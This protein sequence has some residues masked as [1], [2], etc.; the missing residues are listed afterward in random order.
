MKIRPDRR[1]GCFHFA[2]HGVAVWAQERR[3]I[4]V[5]KRNY[6]N[7]EFR[8]QCK[9]KTSQ[10]EFYHLHRGKYAA[11]RVGRVG[12]EQSRWGRMV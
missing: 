7:A 1:A 4:T 2:K 3:C 9:A 11:L 10:T 5:T 12:D 8:Q 6:A